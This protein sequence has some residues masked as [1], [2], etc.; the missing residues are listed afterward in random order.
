MQK[1]CTKCKLKKELS[2]FYANNRSTDKKA[3]YC[4]R[5]HE[6]CCAEWRKNNREKT[7]IYSK[8]WLED[9][10]NYAKKLSFN[11]K[12]RIMR[13]NIDG[14]HS[15]DEWELLKRQYHYTCPACCEQE[16]D[17]KLGKDHIIP[18][19]MGGTN[20]IDNIQPLCMM[21]NS[22]KHTHITKY[23]PTHAEQKRN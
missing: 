20:Y 7:Q 13:R 10:G 17:I 2:E 5:C 8:K 4:K 14:F 6:I 11:T 3:W 9:D 12:S 22:K 16:P 23:E 15:Q 18:I 19:S 1:E 21:C